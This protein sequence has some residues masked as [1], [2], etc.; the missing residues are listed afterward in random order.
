[1][2]PISVIVIH[3]LLL[4]IPAYSHRLKKNQDTGFPE[5]KIYIS[6]SQYTNLQTNNNNKLVLSH[7]LM[8]INS[9]TAKVKEIHARGNNSLKYSHKSLSVDL[10]KPITLHDG[11]KK[12][13]LKKF[14]LLN[15]SM[16]KHRWHNRWSDL[17]L[18]TMGIFPLFNSYCKVWINDQPQGI[19]LLIEKPQH[20]KSTLKSPYMLRRG[21]DHSISDEYF[22]S[23]DKEAAKKYR[24]QFQSIYT[25]MHAMSPDDYAKHL[26]QIM[27]LESYS[28]FLAFNY[29]VMNGDY[30]DEV[31]L[32]IEPQKQ[33]FEVIPWDYDDILKPV[34]HEG[35]TER[36]KEHSDKK[37]FSLEE[38]LDRAIAA[39]PQLYSNYEQT[40]RQVL[41]TLDST[42]LT[43]AAHR[44]IH[45]LE[46]IS[47]DKAMADASLFLDTTPFDFGQAK[48]D[49]LF[50]LDM[51][52][53]RRNWIL[54][55]LK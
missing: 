37:L 16:D 24:K 6:K 39:N 42:T 49:I 30:A 28:K 9:D 10:G 5:I 18:E 25:S 14:D 32:Y 33:W 50:S 12:V 31:F 34:P 35:R 15:L 4:S 47:S 7:P 46:Q 8:L 51:I 52:L 23:E 13:Q 36:N 21:P 26:Q 44:V 11:N 43:Q 55:E 20:V 27:N 2:K 40:L 53:K 1:M 17:N 48:E 54:E 41:L 45:E 22:E 19:Y 38:S 3:L 29:L